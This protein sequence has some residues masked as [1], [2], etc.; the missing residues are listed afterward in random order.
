MLA[1]GV[2]ALGLPAVP[3]VPPADPAAPVAPIGF[4]AF[5][6]MNELVLDPAV[7]IAPGV[8]LG[9]AALRSIQPSSVTLSAFA[10]ALGAGWGDVVLGAG[11]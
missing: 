11:V 5:E 2:S 8:A 10:A 3:T 7:P 6:S 4:A 9:L 1:D